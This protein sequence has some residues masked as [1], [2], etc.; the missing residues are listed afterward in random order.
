MK[1]LEYFPP[2]RVR[3]EKKICIMD[4]NIKN[5]EERIL[6]ITQEEYDEAMAKGWTDD[7]I[8]KPGKH[9][10]RRRTRKINLREAKI[11]MTMFIDGDILQHFR[12]RAAAPN[13][14]PYQTQINQELRAAM[15]RDLA[16]EEN[17]LDE[18]AKKLLNNPNFLEA[19][20]EKLKAA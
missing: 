10:F 20:S 7:D 11:K 19:I 6:E 8:S 18:M 1:L 16:Q 9:I 17:N 13:A 14:A 2:E 3:K 4:K 5:S 12:R 15:E